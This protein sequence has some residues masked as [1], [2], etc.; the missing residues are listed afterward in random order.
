[1]MALAKGFNVTVPFLFK[2]LVDDLNAAASASKK[3]GVVEGVLSRASEVQ[4]EQVRGEILP[5]TAYVRARAYTHT[6]THTRKK[7]QRDPLAHPLTPPTRPPTQTPLFSQ[8]VAA[9]DA[10]AVSPFLVLTAYGLSRSMTSLL[11]ESRN[12]VFASVAQRTIR[13][14]GTTTFSHLH[15]LDLKYHLDANTGNLTRV[16]ERG[17]RSMR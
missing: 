6:N 15:E 7:T 11:Q 4:P 8:L 16:L 17:T 1:M 14:L 9:A 5:N 3:G 13:K 2:S 10:L 12:A